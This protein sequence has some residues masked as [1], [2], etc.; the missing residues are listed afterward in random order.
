MT[1]AK[2]KAG[3]K[4]TAKAPAKKAKSPLKKACENDR[5][6][7][8]TAKKSVAKK[9]AKKPAPK[10]AAAKLKHLAFGAIEQVEHFSAA[11]EVVYRALTEGKLHSAFTGRGREDFREGRR[12]VQG[13]RK[14]HSRSHRR[15][16][17]GRAHRAS[18]A[19]ARFS[20]GLSRLQSRDSPD[21][22]KR[23][24]AAAPFAHA[25]SRGE[26]R[27]L[28]LGLAHEILAAAAR[29]AEHVAGFGFAEGKKSYETPLKQG[30]LR[31]DAIDLLLTRGRFF[32]ERSAR[33]GDE[34]AIGD[35]G[36]S[37]AKRRIGIVFEAELDRF[38]EI[39]PGDLGDQSQ[40]EIDPCRDAA[41]GDA[42]AIDD[43]ARVFHL[44]AERGQHFLIGPVRRCF[45]TFEQ[46][47]RAE[48]QCAGADRSDVFGCFCLV[49]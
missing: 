46:A 5:E 32:G 19:H 8:A 1:M 25:N 41:A 43:D 12:G 35:V 24:N 44:R 40:T 11:P 6:E 17:A 7:K 10:T 9:S 15:A 3:A 36:M 48:E 45:V 16:R 49:S 4:K 29:V 34:R 30:D 20:E 14:I 28:R 2:P 39:L 33:C 13:A 21:S 42:R 31:S 27:E 38:C 18:M 47:R 23:R 22:G 37:A 26:R